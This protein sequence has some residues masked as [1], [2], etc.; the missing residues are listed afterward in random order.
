[1]LD[2]KVVNGSD[3][4]GCLKELVT[5]C[6]MCNDSGLAYNEVCLMFVYV[7]IHVRTPIC[8]CVCVRACVCVCVCVFVRACVRACVETILCTVM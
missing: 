8:V 5:I 3:F 2:G 7:C 1:M 6:V 4:A